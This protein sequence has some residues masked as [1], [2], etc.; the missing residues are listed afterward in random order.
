MIRICNGAKSAEGLELIM[1]INLCH[2]ATAFRNKLASARL[3]I[4]CGVFDTC[5]HGSWRPYE[6]QR[7][8]VLENSWE[9][10]PRDAA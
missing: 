9:E 10:P 1:S 5:A 6:G 8:V 2:V 7:V 4:M 3:T